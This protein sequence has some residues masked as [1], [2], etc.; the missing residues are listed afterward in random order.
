[1]GGIILK[2]KKCILLLGGSTDQ[3]FII[4]SAH[5]LGLETVVIDGNSDAPGLSLGTYSAPIDFSNIPAVIE[6]VHKLKKQG[7]NVCG[8][9]VMGSD[10]P[11]IVAAIA[12]AFSWVGPSTET[13]KDRKSVV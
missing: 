10:V 4:K 12:K 6:Y 9:T 5:E 3:L 13:G 1:M 8:V 11:H 2:S 7:I